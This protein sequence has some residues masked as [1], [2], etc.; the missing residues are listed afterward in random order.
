MRVKLVEFI[1]DSLD[2]DISIAAM[3]SFTGMSPRKFTKAFVR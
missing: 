1:E 2:E 3:S